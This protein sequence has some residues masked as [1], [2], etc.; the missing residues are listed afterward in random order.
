M[1][2]SVD[3]VFDLLSLD[4]LQTS[5]VTVSFLGGLPHRVI[6][7]ELLKES[8]LIRQALGFTQISCDR[9]SFTV[10]SECLVLG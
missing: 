10:T 3:S 5:D 6:Y 1:S 9:N 8:F 2:L 4:G 7:I